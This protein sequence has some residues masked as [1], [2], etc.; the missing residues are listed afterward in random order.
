MSSSLA[1]LCFSPAGATERIVS[2]MES[3][4]AAD[5]TRYNLLKSDGETRKFT[6]NDMVVVAVPVYGGR[7]P[8]PALEALRNFSGYRTPAVSVVVYGNRAYEDSLLELNDV[9][10]EQGFLVFASGAFVARHSI[11]E[12]M[13]AGRPDEEDEKEMEQFCARIFEQFL[14]RKLGKKWEEVAV[15]G[16]RPYREYVPAA[17]VP[18]TGE[19]CTRCGHCVSE[20]PAGAMTLESTDAEKCF[21]CMRCVSVC[22]RKARR[23]PEA[24]RQTVLAR[25]KE[26]CPERNRNEVFMTEWK[27]S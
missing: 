22:P 3:C 16:N 8:A 14:T 27:G 13:G 17:V 26:V 9:L 10:K 4:L 18:Y 5:P 23:L 20:C 11:A 2:H 25:L 15:P 6:R 7:V 1:F 19:G 21:L 12:E 24:F